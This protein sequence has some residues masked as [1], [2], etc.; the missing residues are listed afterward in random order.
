[1]KNNRIFIKR[2]YFK[3]IL[4]VSLCFIFEIHTI[5]SRAVSNVNFK[6]E[7]DLYLEY[8]KDSNNTSS[9]VVS[10]STRENGQIKYLQGEIINIYLNEIS[11]LGLIG[12]VITD[13]NGKGELQAI[14]EN[15]NSALS[16]QTIFQ[17][18]ALLKDTVTYIHEAV[19]LTIYES[20]LEIHCFE[21]D[22]VKYLKAV[23]SQVDSTGRL[24]PLEDF[25]IHFYVQRMLGL[26]P[27]GGDYT[28]TDEDGAISIEFPEDLAGDPDGNIEIFI[29]VEDEEY[30]GNIKNQKSI[31]WGIPL[32]IEQKVNKGSLIGNRANAP[33]FLIAISNIIIIGVWIVILYL[34]F[35]IYKIRKLGSRK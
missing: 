22:S 24:Y 27:I 33:M 18:Y 17:F 20:N 5:Y 2:A 19:E 4:F 21:E 3:Y 15:F 26:L 1:M 31:S 8:Y 9:L 34:V 11:E 28:Y 23:F 29:Q 7:P 13:E 6:I 30:F 25:E 14:E 10:L 12:I 32:E 16:N 35:Q